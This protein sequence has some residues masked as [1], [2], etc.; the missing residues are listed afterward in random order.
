MKLGVQLYSLRNFFETE[1]DTLMVF[2]ATKDMG[3]EICQYSGKSIAT[4]DDA[5][6]IRRAADE[7]G[8]KLRNGSFSAAEIM[9]DPKGVIEKMNI[10]GTEYTMVGSMP[11]ELRGSLDGAIKFLKDMEE[12]TKILMDAG[13]TIN[14]HNHDFEFKPLEDGSTAMERILNANNGWVFMLDVCWSQFAGADTLKLMD[15]MGAE[16]LPQIHFKDMTGELNEKGRPVFCPCGTGLVNF[17]PIVEKAN[18]FGIPEMFVE[19]DNAALL[20]DPL[21]QVEASCK[22]LRKLLGKD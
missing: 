20:P 11:K 5:R 22:Y 1:A 7:A 19:Q 17:A 14:Y 18:A 4:E 6:L 2:K 21:G 9:A 13:K 3:Y 8:I 12:P 15:E 10:L 16:R